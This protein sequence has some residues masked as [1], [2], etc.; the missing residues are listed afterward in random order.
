MKTFHRVTYGGPG[1]PAAARIA[2]VIVADDAD[3]GPGDPLFR[4]EPME[5][6]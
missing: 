2:A 3:V 6:P 5:A 1:L 4:L